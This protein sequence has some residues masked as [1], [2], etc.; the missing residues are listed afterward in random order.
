MLLETA[1]GKVA[2]GKIHIAQ[3]RKKPE[4]KKR[5]QTPNHERTETYQKA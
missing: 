2:F 4:G 1:F 3:E 5:K